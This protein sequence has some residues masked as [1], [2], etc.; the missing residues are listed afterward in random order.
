MRHPWQI[1][2]IEKMV[3]IVAALVIGSILA[4]G[5]ANIAMA[6]TGEGEDQEVKVTVKGE[7]WDADS[8]GLAYFG[9]L[10]KAEG[11]KTSARRGSTD[12]IWRCCYL[13]ISSNYTP[14]LWITYFFLDIDQLLNL[15]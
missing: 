3:F 2:I 4:F 15:F 5:F 1:S 9:A 10:S 11:K 7:S 12:Y 8:R 6:Q 14:I 13:T